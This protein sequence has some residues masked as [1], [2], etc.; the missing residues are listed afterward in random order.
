M[1]RHPLRLAGVCALAL[2][3]LLTLAGCQGSPAAPTA[4]PTAP[5]TAEP[6]PAPSP[7]AEPSVTPASGVQRNDIYTDT[8]HEG[9]WTYQTAVTGDETL[10]TRTNGTGA[11]EE[12]A[13]LPGAYRLTYVPMTAG[14]MP[15]DLLYFSSLQV[16]KGISQ[17]GPL[18]FYHT[19]TGVFGP[20]FDGPCSSLVIPPRNSSVSDV[21]WALF[22]S[23]VAAVN[24]GD[25]SSDM[26]LTCPF[27]EDFFTAP[28]GYAVRVSSLASIGNGL[29]KI[30][31]K[32]Y[33][34]ESDVT[35]GQ[36]AY[37]AYNYVQNTLNPYAETED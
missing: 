3:A 4:A 17:A 36:V 21:G 2:A 37:Y 9:D 32:D 34:A 28:E 30:T 29:L 7:T 19:G 10:V 25:G 8:L 6:T 27:E 13:R 22:G 1:R 12:L 14:T 24:L 15:T 11:V 5:Q 26:G 16:G 23:N 20:V 31:I 35:P 33:V 18:Y